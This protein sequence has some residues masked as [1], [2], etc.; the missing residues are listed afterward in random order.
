MRFFYLFLCLILPVLS[1][2]QQSYFTPHNKADGLVYYK[3]LVYRGCSDLKEKQ[4][5]LTPKEL[6]TLSAFT[7]N[8]V[9]ETFSQAFSENPKVKASFEKDLEQL[10]KDPACFKEGNDCRVKLLGLALYYYQTFRPDLV[11]CKSQQKDKELCEAEKKFRQTSLQGV[12]ASVYGA[13]PASR[14]KKQILT[15][16]NSLTIELF[17]LI[18]HKDQKNLHICNSVQGGLVH[19]YALEMNE[20]GDYFVGLDPDYDPVKNIQKECVDEKV[21]LHQEFILSQF[22][23]GRNTVGRDQVEPLR[24]LITDFIKKNPDYLVTDVTVTVSSSKTPHYATV[25]GK[26][27]LDPESNTKNLAI[28]SERAGFVTKLLGEIRESSGQYQKMNLTARAEL[29]GPEFE[30]MD[31]NDRFVTRMT[32]G[33]L[34]KVEMLYKKFQKD[35]QGK[36]FIQDSAPLMD[37]KLYVNLYQA[38]YKPFHGFSINFTGHKKE[39]M[40]CTDF[41][42]R[43]KNKERLNSRQ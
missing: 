15:T 30:P 5:P 26:K 6:N 31:L 3:D 9:N 42:S 7:K 40:K 16:K 24:Q 22:D 34:D 11:E 18:M 37:E 21:T 23:E 32:P 12:H 27:I 39:E 41:I 36:A 28:A 20:P 19:Q 38:K 14:Y 29:A 17:K 43:P 8:L 35:Y 1:W 25:N 13:S 10:T 2:A 33:Y 4:D